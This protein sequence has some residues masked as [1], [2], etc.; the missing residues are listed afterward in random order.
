MDAAAR[1]HGQFAACT[2]NTMTCQITFEANDTT[3]VAAES[4]AHAAIGIA[5]YVPLREMDGGGASA[6][7]HLNLKIH[8]RTS[9]KVFFPLATQRRATTATVWGVRGGAHLR[10]VCA[11][12]AAVVAPVSGARMTMIQYRLTFHS[13]VRS[14]LACEAMHA[15]L[16]AATGAVLEVS[17]GHKTR[18]ACAGGDMTY[19][20]YAGNK[21]RRGSACIVCNRPEVVADMVAALAA[22]L[23]SPSALL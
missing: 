17:G 4:A 3:L 18:I 20:I 16:G 5:V 13:G 2:V 9:A 6:V 12:L 21:A 23:S 19:V 22:H 10:E 14:A 8:G 1:A 15:L 11:A 7:R